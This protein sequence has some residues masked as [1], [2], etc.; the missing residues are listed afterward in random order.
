MKISEQTGRVIWIT[1]L[2][3]AGKTTVAQA[4]ARCLRLKGVQPV[5]LDGDAVRDAVRDPHTGHD[6]V[7]RLA[8]AYRICRLAKLL[9]DQGHLVLVATMSL[10]SEIHQ[11]NRK[12]L[13][14]YLEVYLKVDWES[15][16]A[17]DARGLYSRFDQGN[18][19]NI[20]GLDLEFDEP[21]EPDLVLENQEPFIKPE[22]LAKKI[23]DHLQATRNKSEQSI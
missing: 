20:A 13:P 23:W 6:R 18:A 10:F 8:N 7:S 19:D 17:R 22:Q 16:V 14:N 4:V 11:W 21:S 9:A 12:Q 5:V 2:S 15:L 1:G 3:G